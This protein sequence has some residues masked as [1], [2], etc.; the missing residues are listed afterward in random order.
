MEN[1]KQKVR[2]NSFVYVSEEMKEKYKEGEAY[3]NEG[4]NM[5]QTSDFFDFLYTA[6]F[7]I[8]ILDSEL[9]SRIKKDEVIT[10]IS[11]ISSN[12]VALSPDGY[13]IKLHDTSLPD[14]YAIFSQMPKDTVLCFRK[15]V[16]MQNVASKSDTTRYEYEKSVFKKMIEQ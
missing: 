10:P 11:E 14:K 16:L 1:D 12:T 7:N 2:I 15:N 5:Q 8:L 9:Y 4:I 6:N 3:V 13:C